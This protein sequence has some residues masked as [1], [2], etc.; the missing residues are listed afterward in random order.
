[1]CEP[2]KYVFQETL[3]YVSR[4]FGVMVMV[5]VGG[6]RPLVYRDEKVNVNIPCIHVQC[7]DGGHYNCVKEWQLYVVEWDSRR[8]DKSIGRDEWNR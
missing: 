5:H 8:E 3:G 6:K 1:M 7:L 2:R 4:L